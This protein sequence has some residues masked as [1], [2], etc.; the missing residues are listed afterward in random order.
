MLYPS[1]DKLLNIVDSKYKLVT[2]ASKRSKQILENNHLK[3]KEK[4][5]NALHF[6]TFEEDEVTLER[7]CDISSTTVLK[8]GKFGH[9][10]IKSPYGDME[11]KTK[12]HKVVKNESLWAVEYSVICENEEILR[13]RLE[14]NIQYLS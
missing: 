4:D 11:M 12:T 5:E 9:S 2:V 8:N 1:I 14:W 3:Y 6:V 7:K 10:T 13:Q